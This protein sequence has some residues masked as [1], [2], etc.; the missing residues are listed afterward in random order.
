M[1]LV[2]G[3]PREHDA[4]Q[5]LTDLIGPI[6]QTNWGGIADVKSIA[7]GYDLSM[8]DRALEPH[9]ELPRRHLGVDPQDRP[10]DR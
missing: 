4:L 6:R 3:L 10:N 2:R 9:V 8:T 5:L 1:A 7:N